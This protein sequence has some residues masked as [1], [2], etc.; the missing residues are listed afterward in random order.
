MAI[1]TVGELF[2]EEN[3]IRNENRSF[4]V[5]C[6]SPKGELLMIKKD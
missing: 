6:I 3:L 4:G 1:L 2:G 5:K